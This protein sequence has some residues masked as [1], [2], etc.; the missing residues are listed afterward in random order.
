M[1][2]TFTSDEFKGK[3]D[4]LKENLSALPDIVSSAATSAPPGMGFTSNGYKPEGFD[5]Y[6]MF[7]VVD[8]DYDYIRTMGLQVTAGRGFSK[9]FMTDKDA[10]L[11]NE[12]LVR[13]LNWQDPVGKNIFRNGDH[14]VIGVVKDF[15]FASL[16]QEIGPLIFTMNPYLG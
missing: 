13:H 12:T 15:H 11:I 9:D 8:V 1:I 7:N 5:S 16:R 10:Y 3:V 2:M 14:T 4:Q 6:R